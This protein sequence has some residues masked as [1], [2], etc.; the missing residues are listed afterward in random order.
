MLLSLLPG[1]LTGPLPLPRLPLG[2]PLPLPE[3]GAALPLL[4]GLWGNEEPFAVGWLRPGAACSSGLGWGEGDGLWL[5]EVVPLSGPSPPASALSAA[6][7]GP[8]A[9]SVMLRRGE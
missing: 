3:P 1:L 6:C 4:Q 7:S 9:G 8:S 2:L 5:L